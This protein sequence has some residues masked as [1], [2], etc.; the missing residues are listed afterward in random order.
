[1]AEAE[2]EAVVQRLARLLGA[3]GREAGVLHDLGRGVVA[4][5]RR[6]PDAPARAASSAASAISRRRATSAGI[7]PTTKVRVKSAQ[8]P[9]GSSCGQTSISIGR[10]AG[11]GPLPGFARPPTRR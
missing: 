8:Q 1:V 6:L 7:S 9:F 2:G 5:A 3:L 10:R 11:S 4:R